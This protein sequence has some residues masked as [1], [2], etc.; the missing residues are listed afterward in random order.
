[1]NQKLVKKDVIKKFIELI[2]FATD[3]LDKIVV[4]IMGLSKVFWYNRN[5]VDKLVEDVGFFGVNYDVHFNVAL[6]NYELAR[7]EWERRNPGKDFK[8]RGYQNSV[9]ALSCL[10]ID[11]DIKGSNHTEENLPESVQEAIELAYSCKFAP[12]IIVSS[13]G[14]LH[15]Y[16][17]FKEQWRLDTNEERQKAKKV[18]KT[19]QNHIREIGR[20]KGWNIDLTADLI[21]MLRFPGTV[22]HKNEPIPVEIIEIHENRR[23]AIKEFIDIFGRDSHEEN[24][25]QSSIDVIENTSPDIGPIIEGCAFI[26][27]TIEDSKSLPEPEWYI[28]LGILARCQNGIEIAHKYS[29]PH[30]GYSYDK[31]QKKLEH[32]LESAGPRTCDNICELTQ[33]QYCNQCEYKDKITSPIVLG[34]KNK[35]T[36]IDSFRMKAET[37]AKEVVEMIKGGSNSAHL[38]KKVVEAFAT[39][40]ELDI[41]KFTELKE[42][43]KDYNVPIR[44][45]NRAVNQA[46]K[47]VSK[48]I[49]EFEFQQNDNINSIVKIFEND[50]FIKLSVPGDYFIRVSGIFKL[51]YSNEEFHE[52]KI[53]NYPV[54]IT[55]KFRDIL[56]AQ[57]KVELIWKCYSRIHKKIVD[58][59]VICDT[60]KLIE[61]S[62]EG[63]PVNSLNA[64]ELVRYL[65][66]FEALNEENFK[67][68]LVTSTLGWQGEKLQYGFL[69]NNRVITEDGIV[70][71]EENTESI[72]ITYQPMTDGDIQIAQ[73]FKQAGTYEEWKRIISL[74]RPYPKVLTFMYASFSVPLLEILGC[75]NFI[76]ELAYR[77]SSGKSSALRIAASVWG[78]SDEKSHQ[79]IISSWDNTNVYIERSASKLNGLPLILDD[80]KRAKNPYHVANVIYMI[81]NGRGRGRGNTKSIS[82]TKSW[83]TVL[84]STGET[85]LI[86]FTNDGGVKGRVLEI[87]GKP[88]GQTTDKTRNLITNL[89][90]SIKDNYG[91]AGPLFVDY[92][93]KNKDKW[94]EW[95][96][97]FREIEKRFVEK[98]KN[99][100]SGRL[101][102][103]VAAIELTSILV[104]EA[105]ILPWKHHV[106]SGP[107]EEIWED[108]IN[109]SGDASGEV[110]ALQT[111]I[112]WATSNENRFY[113]R[114]SSS[115]NGWAGRWDEGDH[116]NFIAFMPHIIKDILKQYEFDPEAILRGWQDLGWLETTTR[117]YTKQLRLSGKNTWV[118]V[119]K[120]EAVDKMYEGSEATILEEYNKF[121]F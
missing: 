93:I 61:L 49:K 64:G 110:A 92:L 4:F 90:M 25:Q 94:K 67:Y 57:E 56:I 47:E 58:R 45:F 23:Y 86:R 10:Y 89:N 8:G 41:R 117:K 34:N 87:T 52:Q 36:K 6:Q 91:F 9:S 97:M 31:T 119:I 82:L 15:A 101:A 95:K 98:S 14:G 118:V 2:F 24:L 55:G 59:D 100:V 33:G 13:G 39:L 38:D 48:K 21:R 35:L 106:F 84:F 20:Q 43:L 71:S 17:L 78:C 5:E 29:S 109:E 116:W 28:S 77:T 73:G 74:I 46:S 32:A 99:E 121:P 79:S 26:R 44:D 111:V 51:V 69:L 105:E 63:F 11:I 1:M 102:E 27:H 12:S 19:F 75:S 107:I 115:Q 18:S 72:E 62:K 53:A 96:K 50:N 103:Y 7:E 104:H 112:S 108:I 22:N 66:E 70:S 88:W 54:L 120:R 114:A 60:R 3:E 16:W 85:P 42:K 81:A 76:I 80:T 113:G 30:P 68:S 65:T 37:I 83:R 40:K